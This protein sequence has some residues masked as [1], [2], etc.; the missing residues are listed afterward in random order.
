M[1]SVSRTI[2]LAPVCGSG[3]KAYS[4]HTDEALRMAHFF[5]PFRACSTCCSSTL[6]STRFA[7]EEIYYAG[8]EPTPS[9]LLASIWLVVA[10][11]KAH[12]RLNTFERLNNELEE[13]SLSITVVEFCH[14]ALTKQIGCDKHTESR[15]RLICCYEYSNSIPHIA[16]RN[17]S[18]HVY[19]LFFCLE[20]LTAL[21]DH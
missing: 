8:V 17:R 16:A 21:V 7:G 19:S 4:K 3:T 1:L 10:L 18:I 14:P 11:Q 5:V 12:G 2:S 15:N 20:S 13:I 9:F 6:L